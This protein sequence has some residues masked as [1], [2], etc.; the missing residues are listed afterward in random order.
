M[1]VVIVPAQRYMIHA[2]LKDMHD[3]VCTCT[4]LAVHLKRGP[5]LQGTATTASSTGYKPQT[6]QGGLALAELLK[7]VLEGVRRGKPV[8]TVLRLPRDNS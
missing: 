1:Y 7:D 5:R 3:Y 6:V 2:D 4:A 8:L